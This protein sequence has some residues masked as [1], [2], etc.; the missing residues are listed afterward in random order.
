MDVYVYCYDV[1]FVVWCWRLVML[2][3]VK[4]CFWKKCTIVM[5]LNVS[6]LLGIVMLRVFLIVSFGMLMFEVIVSG[7][8]LGKCV[9]IFSSV[10]LLLVVFLIWMLVMV[11]RLIVVVTLC[12]NVLS[13]LLC[14]VCLVMVMFELTFSCVCGMMVVI[15]LFLCVSTLSEC[16]GLGRCFCMSSVLLCSSVF[17]FLWCLIR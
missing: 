13:V 16:L 14:R 4:K 1:S 12:V 11:V 2:L 8:V 10:G 3:K 6:G 7:I 17:S 15:W 9:L 5:L